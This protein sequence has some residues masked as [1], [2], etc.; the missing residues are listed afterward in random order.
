MR[1]LATLVAVAFLSCSLAFGQAPALKMGS[2]EA[3]NA[4]AK[5]MNAGMEGTT[6]HRLEPTDEAAHP[7]LK[8]TKVGDYGWVFGVKSFSGYVTDKPI[9][10]VDGQDC[11][12]QGVDTSPIKSGDQFIIEIP[13]VVS[14]NTIINKTKYPIVEPY[15]SWLKKKSSPKP[16]T[17]RTF[18]PV[19][20]E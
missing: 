19:P 2:R 1:T 13:L 4:I 11:I 3:A 16:K 17:P 18:K 20:L 9:L 14:G 10:N 7:E 5:A 12:L 15:F 8:T 6:V